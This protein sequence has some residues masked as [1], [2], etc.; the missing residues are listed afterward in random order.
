MGSVFTRR[1][2]LAAASAVAFVGVAG[3]SARA[4]S[5]GIELTDLG[6]DLVLLQGAG[7]NVVALGTSDGLLLVDGGLAQHAPAVTA[8]LNQR[9][10]GRKVAVLF[11]TNWRDEHVGSNESARA[12]GAKVCAHENTK[13]WLGGDFDVE[14]EGRHYAPRPAKALPNSTFYVSGGLEL[15]GRRIEYWYL[16]RAHTDGDVAVFFP[17]ANVL[18]ASD[19]L[20]VGRYPVPDY[21]TGG[22]I[23][24]MLAA[25][26]SLLEKTDAATRIVPAVGA[27]AGR[28]ELAAQQELCAA[29]RD[30]AA[31]AFRSGMSL[32]DF[33]ASKPTAAFDAKWGDP[34]LFL[35][36]VYKGGFA[37]LRELGGVI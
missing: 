32:K 19:L 30:K 5:G 24:G 8:A 31:E 6:H 33:T 3:R 36:L 21:A 25:S 20:S 13:L 16:P 10:P 29:V 9:W 11:N 35:R 4:Q 12:A 17:D 28:P 27:V 15:G 22:W 23:G 34:A 14:W 37:H 18:V 1:R 2:F 26:K 7:A